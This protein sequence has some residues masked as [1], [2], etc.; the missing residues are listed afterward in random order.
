MTYF[1]N[2]NIRN[3]EFKLAFDTDYFIDKTDLIDKIN[4]LINKKDRFLC[5]T[6][7]R[8]FGKT[9]NAMMLESY[10]SKNANF[11]N[12]FDKLKIANSSSY[13]QH[14]NKHNVIYLQLNELPNVSTNVTYEDFINYYVNGLEK[15]LKN[16]W[17]EIHF[18]GRISNRLNQ[19]YSET[20]EGFIF[21]I[22][23]RNW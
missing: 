14:L 20:G 9:I 3:N 21:I 23:F 5:I 17:P 8:R 7:P 10:Y 12:I 2:R 11:K 22:L 15:D 1:I 6:R 19:V 18:E 13:L 4:G 16:L